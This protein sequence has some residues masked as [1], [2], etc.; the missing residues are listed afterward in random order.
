[1]RFV[2]V[3]LLCLCLMFVPATVRAEPQQLRAIMLGMHN[4][5][6]ARWDVP[7][8]TWDDALADDA[9]IY[10]AQLARSGILEHAPDIG[11][12][13]PVGENLWMGTRGAF[14]YDEM[15][16]SFLDE[17]SVYVARA[18][19]DI[20][21]TGRWSDAAHYSQIVWRTT[22]VVGCGVASGR[23]FDVLVCRYDPAGNI[24]GRTANDDRGIDVPVTRIASNSR[25]MRS[26]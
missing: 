20:S 22:T 19:P 18:I 8:L 1:M 10:A 3:A 24:W 25:I 5:E 21:R 14:G 6:R 2:S 7:P 11:G 23:D 13:R 15:V 16:G 12:A 17:R 26:R 4:A 9:R